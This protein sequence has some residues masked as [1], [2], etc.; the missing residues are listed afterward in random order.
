VISVLPWSAARLSRPRRTV[1]GLPSEGDA[2][3][4]RSFSAYRRTTPAPGLPAA[5]SV[6]PSPGCAGRDGMMGL[7]AFGRPRDRSH[8]APAVGLR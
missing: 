4:G 1:A 2:A 3:S 5:D 7:L 6:L 8:A